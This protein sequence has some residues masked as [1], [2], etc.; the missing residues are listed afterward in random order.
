MAMDELEREHDADAQKK[1]RQDEYVA[2]LQR[3]KDDM[4]A[5]RETFGED[6]KDYRKW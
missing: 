1:Q 3:W 5:R 4:Q 6:L 2:S